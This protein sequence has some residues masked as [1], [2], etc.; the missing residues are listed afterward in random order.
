MDV[1]SISY[2]NRKTSMVFKNRVVK[3]LFDPKREKVTGKNV[4]FRRFMICT[5][6]QICFKMRVEEGTGFSMLFAMLSVSF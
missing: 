5:R 2:M 3:R 1:N 4:I 6:H